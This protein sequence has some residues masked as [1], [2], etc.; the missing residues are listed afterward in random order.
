M[1]QS[2]LGYV[3]IVYKSGLISGGIRYVGHLF[4][5]RTLRC[6]GVSSG[7]NGAAAGRETAS[8]R[9]AA[10]PTG[11]TYH[12]TTRIWTILPSWQTSL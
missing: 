7:Q 10:D 4:G 6:D 5:F 8:G 2:K 12:L 11:T 3:I 9:E 1:A